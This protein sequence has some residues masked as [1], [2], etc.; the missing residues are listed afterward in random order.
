LKLVTLD[1]LL[2]LAL[3]NGAPGPAATGPFVKVH[4]HLAP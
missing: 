3:A 2:V 4:D 1:A